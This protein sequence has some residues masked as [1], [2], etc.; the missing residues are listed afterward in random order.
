M[1]EDILPDDYPVNFGYAYMAD[2]E[3]I[4][5]D[6]QGDVADLKAHTGAK[7]IRRCDLV[8]R[9]RRDAI[10]ICKRETTP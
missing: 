5:A 8:G 2:G 1:K 3:V 4:S 9:M 10:A 7:E 6:I